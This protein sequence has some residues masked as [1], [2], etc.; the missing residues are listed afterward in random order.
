M[1]LLVS[2]YDFATDARPEDVIRL[3]RKVIPTG[4][5]HGT[6]TVLFSQHQL[7][8]TTFRTDG[9]YSDLRRPDKVHFTPSIFE[10]L[11]R[12][13]FTINSMAYDLVTGE[14][15]DPHDGKKDIK[16]K[17]I[18]A[19]GLPLERFQED[20]LRIMR[21][22]RFAA[23]L[24]FN[25]EAETLSGMTEKASNL[26]A[27]SAERIRDELEKILKAEKPSI[28]FHIMSETGVLDAVLPE[29]AACRGIEQK[30]FHSFDVFE[31]SLYSCDGAPAANPEVR[32]AALLHDIGKPAALDHDE[33][34]IPT[35]YNHEKIS[36]EISRKIIQRFKFPK[37]FEAHVLLLIEHHMF[38]YQPEWTDSAVRRFIAKTGLVNLDNL[39]MLRRA[40]QFGMA[41]IRIDSQNLKELQTRVEAVLEADH[42]FTIRDLNINGNTLNIKAG[43]PKGPVM[44]IILEFL[45][46][47]VLDDPSQNR[48]D[49]LLKLADNFYKDRINPE[50]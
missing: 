15:L 19:I 24:E 38:N 23:Q 30:G 29:L 12:R 43:I 50:G 4:I 45:L 22:C 42:A 2:D 46:E 6:V 11:K 48:E 14:W 10:D 8:V 32:L 33:L 31:H 13:D 20:A 35:F 7:E 39:F 1:G 26:A 44:G 3:F 25:I 41:G 28:A 47:T 34:G 27:V 36:V 21:G 16:L 18:R 17:T 40:D 49:L 37:A 9:D 5:K